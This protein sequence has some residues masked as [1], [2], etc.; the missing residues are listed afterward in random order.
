MTTEQ[1]RPV[2]LAHPGARL[3]LFVTLVIWFAVESG[4]AGQRRPEAT[5]QDRGSV[6]ILRV[7]GAGGAV[8]AA[9]ALNVRAAAFA[10]GLLMFSAGLA[11]MLSGIGL[12]WWA[13]H[14][15]G[16]YF[17]FTVMTSADQRVIDTVP[18]RLLRHPSYAGLLLT[19]IGIGLTYGNWPSLVALTLF[20]FVGL[21]N[22]IRVEEAA[23]AS[24]LGSAYA[25]YASTRKRLIPFGW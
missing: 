24:A 4:Q 9:L 18:Y 3:L 10:H 13:F 25:A 21:V 8:L 6:I 16:R 1:V 17:T 5:S 20:P 14:T 19:L 2:F 23:L 15:L 22:R 7:C 11:L 12:R